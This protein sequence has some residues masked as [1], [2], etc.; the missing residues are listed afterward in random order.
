MASISEANPN[1]DCLSLLYIQENMEAIAL[2]DH[3]NAVE[4]VTGSF[5]DEY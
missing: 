4:G 2:D 3:G 5:D 1:L